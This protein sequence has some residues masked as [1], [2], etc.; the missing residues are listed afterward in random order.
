MGIG[1]AEMIDKIIGALV[2]AGEPSSRKQIAADQEGSPPLANA[3]FA[4]TVINH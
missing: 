1:H 4:G 2:A 3:I